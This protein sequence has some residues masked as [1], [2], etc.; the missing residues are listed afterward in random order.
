LGWSLGINLLPAGRKVCSFN[1]VYCQYG[2]TESQRRSER[3][4]YEWPTVDAVERAVRA[5]LETLASEGRPLDHLTLA[6]HGEPTLHPAFDEVV[7]RL[8]RLRDAVVPG[9]RL[10]ILSN[11]TTAHDPDVRR[12]L[13]RLDERFMKL[14]GGDAETLRRI[15]SASVPIDRLTSALAALSPVTV[16]SLFVRDAQGR[17]DNTTPAAVEAW[18][19]ALEAVRPF[20]VHLYSLARRPAL[21]RLRAVPAED[22]HALAQRVRALGTPAVV[23]G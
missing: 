18:L 12:A 20:E 10:S 14:D 7:E 19:R 16:Q 3:T 8:R 5:R 11:S 6:G 23:F 4:P 15:N 21:S 17:L 22:L 13:L 1:C 2:W 9:A